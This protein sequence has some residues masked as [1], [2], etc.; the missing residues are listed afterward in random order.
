[1]VFQYGIVFNIEY[2]K[3]WYISG[4]AKMTTPNHRHSVLTSLT[5]PRSQTNHSSASS[6][7]APTP[8]AE[9]PRTSR[10]CIPTCSINCVLRTSRRIVVLNRRFADIYI[11]VH[12]QT[13]SQFHVNFPTQSS[14]SQSIDVN[15]SN[16]AR[17]SPSYK[18]PVDQVWVLYTQ[19]R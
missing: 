8:G 1:M 10:W 4:R 5:S 6:R 16:A 18:F 17:T 13:C 19:D 9:W 14:F 12:V 11:H 3:I 15:P 7:V 2:D